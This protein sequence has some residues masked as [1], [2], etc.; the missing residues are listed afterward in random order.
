MTEADIVVSSTGSPQTILNRA[1]IA[2]VMVSRRN[3]PLFLIDIAVPRD[4]DPEVQQLSNV[5]LYNVDHLESLVQE[6]VRLRELELEHCQAIIADQIRALMP[7]LAAAPQKRP[8]PALAPA[9]WALAETAMCH[10]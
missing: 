9:G 2:A 6:N 4:I 5:Y 8:E 10:S 1:D 7:K 3:R